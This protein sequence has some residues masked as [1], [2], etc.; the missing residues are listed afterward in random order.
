LVNYHNSTADIKFN[1]IESVVKI[2][3]ENFETIVNYNSR[4]LISDCSMSSSTQSL[5]SKSFV[6]KQHIEDIANS[7]NE[8]SLTNNMKDLTFNMD[9]NANK[10]R[11]KIRSKKL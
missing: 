1:G 2:E 9:F 8:L 10:W 11:D 3:P 5:D 6:I 7:V 4:E